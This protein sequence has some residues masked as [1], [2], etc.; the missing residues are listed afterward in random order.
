MVNLLIF[1]LDGTLFDTAPGILT[2]VNR[3]LSDRGLKAVKMEELVSYIGYG[4]MSLIEDLDR[5]SLGHLGDLAKVEKDFLEYYDEVYLTES[6][7]FEGALNFLKSWEGQLAILSNKKERYVQSMVENCPLSEFNWEACFGGDS[8]STKKPDPKGLETIL[9][10]SGCSKNETVM[11][12]DGVPDVEV[13]RNTG[14]RSLAV[15]FGYGAIEDLDRIG[16][17]GRLDHYNELESIIQNLAPLK[18]K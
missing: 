3:L 1:D 17:H 7:L 14:V 4:V 9:S 16:H 11:I 8:F 6:K 13:A 15:S 12:G 10:M 18:S 5:E 2:A